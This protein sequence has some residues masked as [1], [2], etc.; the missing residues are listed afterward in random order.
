[1]LHA[2]PRGRIARLAVAFAVQR[3]QKVIPWRV[4]AGSEREGKMVE[5]ALTR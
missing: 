1:M 3:S 5:R 4:S 2:H